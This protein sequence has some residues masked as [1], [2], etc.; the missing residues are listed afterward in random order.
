M[1]SS[2]QS[3]N[4]PGR[5]WDTS[6]ASA[7]ILSQLFFLRENIVSSSGMGRDVHALSD[8]ATAGCWIPGEEAVNGR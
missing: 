3:L 4:R 2:V 6:D 5:R 1:Y 7:E 8:V